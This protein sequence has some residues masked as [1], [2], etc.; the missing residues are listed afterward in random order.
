MLNNYTETF[1]KYESC[2]IIIPASE[3][4]GAILIGDF[5]SA[6]DK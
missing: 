2:N 6:T 1:Q 3:T 4:K 5:N